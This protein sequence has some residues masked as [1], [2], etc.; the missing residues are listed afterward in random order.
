LGKK[1]LAS[2]GVDAKI[3]IWQVSTGECVQTL[4]GHTS[5]VN[6]LATIDKHTLA[7]ASNDRSVKI[8]KLSSGKCLQTMIGHLQTVNCLAV[9]DESKIA[10]PILL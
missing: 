10:A 8:W 6:C 7:S 5:D 1:M 3:K 4:K 2:G 9:L